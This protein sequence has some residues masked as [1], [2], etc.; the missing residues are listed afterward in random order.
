M[1]GGFHTQMTFANVIGKYLESSGMAEMW[2]E[3]DVFGETTAGN[4]IKRKLWN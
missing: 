4:I 1:L 3:S 2:A